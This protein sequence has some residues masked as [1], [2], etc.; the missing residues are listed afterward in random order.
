LS[1]Q[2]SKSQLPHPREQKNVGRESNQ[3]SQHKNIIG[4]VIGLGPSIVLNKQNQH[5]SV[6]SQVQQQN[7]YPLSNNQHLPINTQA[8]QQNQPPQAN[9]QAK[10]QNQHP[11]VNSQSQ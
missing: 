1:E 2:S 8:K 6:N 11:A 7:Q 9:S 4:P 5:P 3:Q 10:Q